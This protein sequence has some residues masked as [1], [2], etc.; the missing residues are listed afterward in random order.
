M[1][2]ERKVNMLRIAGIAKTKRLM[3]FLSVVS[4][5]LLILFI[6]WY[7]ES[8]GPIDAQGTAAQTGT[9]DFYA[10][11]TR[12]DYIP[13]EDGDGEDEEEEEEYEDDNEE[14][15]ETMAFEDLPESVRKAARKEYPHQPLIGIDVEREEEAVHYIVMFEVDGREAGLVLNATGSILERWHDDEERE[16][17]DDEEQWKG[18]GPITGRYADIIVN[19]SKGRQFVFGRESSYLPFWKTERGKWF[20]EDIVDRQNDIA[21][22]YSFV[23]IIE[24]ES[25]R[26]LIHWRY[27]PDLENPHGFMGVAHEYFEIFDDGRV[28]RRARKAA[29]NR[30]DYNDPENAIVQ[31]LLLKPDGIEQVSLKHAKLSKRPAEGIKGSPVK[32][33]VVVSP[34]AWW[35]FDEGL[36]RHTY[37]QRDITRETMSGKDCA[38]AGNRTLWKKGVSGTALAFDAYYSSVTMPAA[39]APAIEDELTL[40]AWVV[41][42]AYPWN[43]APVV[44]QSVIDPG[45]I[46]KGTYDEDGRNEDRKN[47][48]GYY[49]G[50][51]PY[52][53]PV[54]TVGDKEL[55]GTTKLTTYRWTHIAGSYGKGKMQIYVDGQPCG[56]LSVSGGIYVPKTDLLI[57]LNNIRGRPTDPVRGPVCHLPGIYGIEGL[58]DEVKIYDITLDSSQVAESYNNLKPGGKLCDK[59]DLERR[60]LPGRPGWSAKFGAEYTELAYHELWDNL[61]R[62]SGYQDVVV[63]FDDYPT[64]I[65]F[66]RGVNG[67]VGW[68]TENNKWMSDQSL[69]VGGPHGCSEHMA[70]KQCRHAHVRIIENT[71]AR[72]VVHWRYASIDVAY[73]FPKARHWTDEYY[74]IYPDCAAVRKVKFRNGNAGWH[75]VQFLN[76]PG[77]GCLDNINLQAVTVANLDGQVRKMTWKGANGVPRNRLRDATISMFNLKSDYK[78]FLV[79]PK[80]CRI[81][82]WGSREQSKHTDDPFAGPWNHWPVSQMPSD[83]RYAITTDR[84][85]HAAVGGADN[86]TQHGNMIIYG[87]TDKPISSLVPLGRSWNNPPKL[88]DVEGCIDR[89]YSMEQRA[90][91]LTAEGRKMSFTLD[92]SQDHPIFNPCF[93]IRSWGSAAKAGL[94]VNGK[95]VESGKSFRQGIIR[96]T[97]G[98]QTLVIWIKAESTEPIRLALN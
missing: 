75:D 53:Y 54:L 31:T 82:T 27:I 18:S 37:A 64:T 36:K 61:W 34:A 86:V 76:Q 11:Y 93:V 4:L 69:E 1:F 63:K 66:W 55:V 2:A 15:I 95:T 29:S 13:M 71:D 57:G 8:E 96:D 35:K 97:N 30:D 84:L 28:I 46:E 67:G 58:I 87:L 94:E 25:D 98:T 78:V 14:E 79:Y 16:E 43:W 12:L 81:G 51:G 45:P 7:E 39:D 91:Q 49:L 70:D 9:D 44:H 90:Y 92:A 3:S 17:E 42:G 5:T 59:P 72:V 41:L 88:T 85:T 26:A 47:G 21:C 50:V 19:V 80:G 20:V 74:Y 48:K 62:G 10:Y 56:E 32:T 6:G 83:G 73:L 89:G 33:R 24:A 68:V 40:E 38:I 65:A 23:R 60:V 77:T 52:G 22:A